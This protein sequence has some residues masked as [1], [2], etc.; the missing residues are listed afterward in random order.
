MYPMVNPWIFYYQYKHMVLFLFYI[1]QDQ[2]KD[3]ILCDSELK[4]RSHNNMDLFL[5][6]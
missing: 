2:D 3:H 6:Q 5:L 1:R 4:L